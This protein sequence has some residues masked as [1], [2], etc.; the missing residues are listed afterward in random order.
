ME[1]GKVWLVANAMASDRI[2]LRN[3]CQ[4]ADIYQPPNVRAMKPNPFSLL[5]LISL[6]AFTGAAAEPD[7]GRNV[8]VK[9]IWDKGAHNAFTD[10]IWFKEEWLCVFREATGHGSHDGGAAGDCFKGRGEV[11]IA[12]ISEADTKDIQHT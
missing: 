7:V 9:K 3:D 8:E 4:Q 2:S 11:G 6:L 10:L 12:G 5:L 1:C